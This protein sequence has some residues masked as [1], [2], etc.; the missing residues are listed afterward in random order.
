MSSHR[1]LVI[2]LYLVPKYD[3]FIYFCYLEKRKIVRLLIK[4]VF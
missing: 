2:N 1:N 3:I 4:N